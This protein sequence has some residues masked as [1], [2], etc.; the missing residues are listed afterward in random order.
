MFGTTLTICLQIVGVVFNIL[1]LISCEFLEAPSGLFRLG[2]WKYSIDESS[3]IFATNGD[4]QDLSLLFDEDELDWKYRAA[5]VCSVLATLSGLILVA[6]TATN[7]CLC[8]LVLLDRLISVAYLVTILGTAFVW[9]IATNDLC[10][11]V[12]GGC[13]WGDGAVYQLVAQCAYILA[14]VIHSCLP[15]PSKDTIPAKDEA[16]RGEVEVPEQ[17]IQATVDAREVQ[18]LRNEL[19]QANNR[20]RALE[21]ENE[22]S[23]EA[24]VSATLTDADT[25]EISNIMIDKDTRA[26]EKENQMLVEELRDKVRRIQE[27]ETQLRDTADKPQELPFDEL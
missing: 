5:Q 11:T 7:D 17:A 10:Q 1:V 12:L 26:Y 23:K 2:V 15:G 19:E 24:L 22:R 20:I 13:V 6:L 21:V 25:I 9:L 14:S 3:N 8:H 4:C 27:L 16:S 18:I